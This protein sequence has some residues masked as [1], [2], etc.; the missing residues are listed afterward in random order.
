MNYSNERRPVPGFPNYTAGACGRVFGKRGPLKPWEITWPTRPDTVYHKVHVYR[1]G[2]RHF[3]FVHRLVCEAFH[4]P[5]PEGFDDVCHLDHNATNNRPSNLRW[6]SHA[7]NVRDA[8][9]ADGIAA[10]QHRAERRAIQAEG[11]GELDELDSEPV[12][13]VPF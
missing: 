4:G 9:S 6:G 5:P 11:C 7:E 1:D 10:R 2:K 8:F 13:G 3:R 12:D